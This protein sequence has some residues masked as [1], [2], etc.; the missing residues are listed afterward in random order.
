MNDINKELRPIINHIAV[1]FL[2]PFPL[3]RM[4]PGTAV[5]EGRGGGLE[6]RGVC[7]RLAPW[8]GCV[9][10]GSMTPGVPA[11]VWRWEGEEGNDLR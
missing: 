1:E 7:G 2:G 3:G 5:W 11:C 9:S 6:L 10:Q 8:V 4:T